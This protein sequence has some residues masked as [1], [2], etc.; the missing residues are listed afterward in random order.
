[1]L[2]S[3]PRRRSLMLIF[4]QHSFWP[5]CS[6]MRQDTSSTTTFKIQ[7]LVTTSWPKSS[8]SREQLLLTESSKWERSSTKG[9]RQFI[10]QSS[11][12]IDFSWTRILRRLKKLSRCL[13]ALSVFIWQLA[14]LLPQ[15]MMKLTTSWYSSGTFKG[16]I[17]ELDIPNTQT[18]LG[19]T[20]W[21]RRGYSWTSMAGI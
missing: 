13:S 4:L 14:S 16:I 6:R 17:R 18:H 11:S 19:P 12:L 8:A 1:M 3:S 2:P 5:R 15:S 7:S 20:S 10:S 9:R 21:R